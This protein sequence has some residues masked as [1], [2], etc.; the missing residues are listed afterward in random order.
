MTT[1][2]STITL[3]DG[4]IF[5][6]IT[7]KPVKD[8]AKEQ[9]RQR[10]AHAI[11]KEFGISLADMTINFPIPVGGRKR[12]ADL[13]VFSHGADHTLENVQRIVLV[14]AEPTKKSAAGLRTHEQAEG[15][16][17]ELEELLA[18]T[19]NAR[20]GMWTNGTELFF[21]E[22]YS[23]KFEER[24]E[25]IADWPMGDESLSDQNFAS[26]QRLRRADAEML[27][28]TFRRCHNFIHGNEGM[29]KDAAFWQ[30]LYLIFAKMQDERA[31]RTGRR[32]FADPRE[33]YDPAGQ[34]KI[35]DRVIP[36]FNAVKKDHPEIF[37]GDEQI[38][39][40]DRALS[41]MVSELGRYEFTRA[42][43]DAKGAAYQEIVGTNLRGDR[44]QYFTPRG[45]IKLMVDMLNP[46]PHE[47]V[48]DPANGTGGFLVSTLDHI[49]QL[50]EDGLDPN[51]TEEQKTVQAK[52]AQYASQNL[53]GADFDP[54]L[55][56]A[57]IMNV[58]MS[59]SGE[60]RPNIY[61]INSLEFPEGHLSGTAEA[62]QHIP[63]GSIDVLMANPPFGS[64]IPITDKNILQHYDLAYQWKKQDDGSF[65][66]T[67]NLQSSVA[68]EV[69]F[70]E[71]CIKWVKPGGRLGLVLPDGILGNPGDEYIRWW[72][73]QHTYVLASVDLPVETFIV[74]ANVN[75]LT[76][77]LLLRRKTEAERNSEMFSP[78]PFEYPVFMA[79]AEK[80]GFDRRGNTLYKRHP[81]GEEIIEE[82]DEE[83]DVRIAGRTET[84]TVRRRR[85]LLDD[86]LPVIAQKYRE[87]RAL[88]PMPS[89]L[90][91][92]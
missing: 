46:Q 43:I 39:L 47:K 68:P 55:V 54:F 75:I 32:F 44:G 33:P 15:D 89:A 29:P 84:R 11:P 35:R 38:T 2:E 17:R 56:R 28:T 24:F 6:Y 78:T 40:S 64:D 30:F 41:F 88:H 69:L 8:S 76:S 51:Q 20:Y 42:E 87:F 21:L 86:D 74:E 83:Q 77:L 48:L 25:P 73:M 80:V 50:F 61:N 23:T 7:N 85:K 37:K 63:L 57:T 81:D 60:V 82:Y 12:K 59:S 3:P 1:A 36:L 67:G 45:P 70:V 31:P 58:V 72:I 14:K 65:M 34:Q 53:F 13:V 71:R 66:N 90:D 91:E 52:L 49:R 62:R 5:D 16:L 27:R 19:P 9:V 79:V 92:A 4:M 26:V 22:R 18:A 10:T